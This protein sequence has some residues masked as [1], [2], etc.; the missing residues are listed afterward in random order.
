MRYDAAVVVGVT[1]AIEQIDAGNFAHRGDDGVDLGG[2][3]PFGKIRNAFDES[4]HEVTDSS[5]G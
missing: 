5:S 2:V 1:F 3:A 4:F